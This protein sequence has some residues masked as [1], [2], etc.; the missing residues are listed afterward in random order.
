MEV[1][2]FAETEDDRRGPSGR[3]GQRQLDTEPTQDGIEVVAVIRR[4]RLPARAWPDS[5]GPRFP[6]PRKSPIKPM[7]T[8]ADSARRAMSRQ[9]RS[10]SP[11]VNPSCT[12]LVAVLFSN[13]FERDGGSPGRF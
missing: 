7:R 5:T 3:Q 1:V 6:R 10:A 13:V 8:D 9:F 11:M 2:D 12:L 4:H